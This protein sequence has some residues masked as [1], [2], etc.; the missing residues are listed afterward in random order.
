[1]LYGLE[2]VAE[3]AVTPVKDPID[4]QAIRAIVVPRPGTTIDEQQ[5]K[6]HCRSNLELRLLPKF[7]E[8]RDQLPK[9]E[10]GKIQRR[11]I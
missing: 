7:I 8:I 10:S 1:M 6:A 4:G 3:A 9:T 2:N 5:V 11:G